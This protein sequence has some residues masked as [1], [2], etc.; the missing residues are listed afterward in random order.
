[1]SVQNGWFTWPLFYQSLALS[2][3]GPIVELGVWLGHSL[4]FLHSNLVAAGKYIHLVGVDAF[5]A[6]G[7]TPEMFEFSKTHDLYELARTYLP[8]E[9]A[10]I[11]GDTKSVASSFPDKYFYA[12]FIDASHDYDSVKNDIEAWLPKT[13]GIIAG[14]DILEPSV[15]SAVESIFP[16]F[17]SDPGQNIWIK[18]LT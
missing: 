9:I 16:D 14:H 4:Y 13:H 6:R 8:L 3:T 2:A 17:C 18:K 1:M 7:G 15:R 5:D 10:L 12:C 11:K